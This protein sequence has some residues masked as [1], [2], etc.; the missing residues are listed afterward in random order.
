[1]LLAALALDVA[2]QDAGRSRPGPAFGGPAAASPGTFPG[3]GTRLQGPVSP[4][5]LSQPV[6]IGYDRFRTLLWL[7]TETSL[8]DQRPDLFALLPSNLSVFTS[9]VLDELPCTPGGP[10]V[11]DGWVDEVAVLDNGNLLLDDYN[12][13]LMRFD[14]T[15]FEIDPSA[16]Q[17]VRN[18]WYL[19][20]SS[21]AGSC[22]PNTNANVPQDSI[23]N[24]AGLA[25][26]QTTIP[27]PMQQIWIGAFVPSGSIKRVQLTPGC[28]GTWLRVSSTPV[29]FAGACD[30]LE[31]DP[32]L[33]SFWMASSSTGLV[34]ETRLDLGTGA[35]SLLQGFP[36]QGNGATGIT[37][38]GGTAGPHELAECLFFPT[39]A[40]YRSHSG[41]VGRGT[42]VIND[43]V[44]PGPIS[45][46]VP[47]GPGVAGRTALAL[48]SITNVAGIPLD[49]ERTLP[50]DPDALLSLMVTLRFSVTLSATG[51]GT[52]AVPI[53]LPPGVGPFQVGYVVLG[54]PVYD[55]S[56]VA[57]VSH[58]VSYTTR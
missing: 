33:Q 41:H 36:G 16:P 10:A 3:A 21:C 43:P 27:S 40:F 55:L 2:A 58:A 54:D 9:I 49:S 47:Q 31:W 18:V 4:P 14:D 1:V 17:R 48:A 57:R 5:P 34:Y 8:N 44:G 53:S 52:I 35:F 6:G 51:T 25:V 46:G 56:G 23:G 22:R 45:I 13:D 11:V 28:P 30:G 29:P 15:L 37:P 38:I 19:D 39:P 20:S 32:D 24:V 26:R 50:Y 42:P 7:A 12:G